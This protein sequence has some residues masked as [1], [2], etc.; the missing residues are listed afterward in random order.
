MNK[1]IRQALEYIRNTNGGAT[2]DIF[3]EDW[4]PIGEKLWESIE[5]AFLAKVDEFGRVRL[6]EAGEKALN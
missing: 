6:T 4:E 3:V 1:T 2:L 5:L